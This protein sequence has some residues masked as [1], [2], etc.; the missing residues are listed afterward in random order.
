ME[1]EING[2]RLSAGFPCQR[3]MDF[4]VDDNICIPNDKQPNVFLLCMFL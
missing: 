4:N 1:T 3:H 2:L